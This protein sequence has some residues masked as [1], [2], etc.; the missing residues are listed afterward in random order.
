[1]SFYDAVTRR[2]KK[3]YARAKVAISWVSTAGV[4]LANILVFPTCWLR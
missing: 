3:P 2:N 1:M 4:T